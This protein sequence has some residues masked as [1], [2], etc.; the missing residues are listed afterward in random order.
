M[1]LQALTYGLNVAELI[2]QSILPESFL[3]MRD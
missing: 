3:K 2:G 1:S